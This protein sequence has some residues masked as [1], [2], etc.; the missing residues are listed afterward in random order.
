MFTLVVAFLPW[1]QIKDSSIHWTSFLGYYATVV[2]LASTVWIIIDRMKRRTEMH[3]FSHFSD[4]LFPIMLFLAALTGIILHIFRVMGLPMETYIIYMI[5]MMIVVPML[6]V[7]VPFGKWGHLLYR[8]LAIYVAVVRSR[9]NE[10]WNQEQVL[11]I[12]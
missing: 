4:W 12:R 2:L 10:C 11:N 9:A 5:H 8:P 1:F 7:E 6:V 3:R